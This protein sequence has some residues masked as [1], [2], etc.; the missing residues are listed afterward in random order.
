MK[1]DVVFEMWI[2][3]A[4]I[5]FTKA[6]QASMHKYNKLD[7]GCEVCNVG[8]GLDLVLEYIQG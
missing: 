1:Y 4:N 3:I 6:F 2:V 5:G 8:S 7:Y